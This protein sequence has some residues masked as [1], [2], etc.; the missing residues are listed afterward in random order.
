[1]KVDITQ[2]INKWQQP[3][4]NAEDL[5]TCLTNTRALADEFKD[6]QAADRLRVQEVAQK[7][8]RAWRI[9][10]SSNNFDRGTSSRYPS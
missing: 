6:H 2:W 5:Q 4:L 1:M 10:K 7:L 3:N 9:Q 8:S